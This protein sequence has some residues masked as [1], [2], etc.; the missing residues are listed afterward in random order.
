MKIIDCIKWGLPN[1]A[2]STDQNGNICAQIGCAN[3]DQ[4]QAD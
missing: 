1:A 4:K 2:I 3:D